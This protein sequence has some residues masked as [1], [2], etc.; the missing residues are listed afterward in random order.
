PDAVLRSSTPDNRLCKGASRSHPHHL[1]P[2]TSSS[3][4]TNPSSQLD[5]LGHNGYTLGVNGTQ[6]SILKKSNKPLLAMQAQHDSGNA[7]QS[8]T[9]A[10][11][12][13]I[14]YLEVLSNFTNQPL[15]GEFPDQKLGTLLTLVASCFLG[16]FPPVDLRAVC[17]VRAICVHIQRKAES[18]TSKCKQTT[19]PFLPLI[20]A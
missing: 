8:A 2:T 3:L 4:T 11:F 20:I 9:T 6:I 14:S 1:F 5:I 15:E 17:F 18:K 10:Q 19:R 16:A 7:D 12:F 13:V